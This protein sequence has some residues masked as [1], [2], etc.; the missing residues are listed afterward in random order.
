M[1]GQSGLPQAQLPCGCP[2][3]ASAQG[4]ASGSSFARLAGTLPLSIAPSSSGSRSSRL[5]MALR[6]FASS[7]R[8]G[9]LTLQEEGASVALRPWATAGQATSMTPAA[10][11]TAACAFP[12]I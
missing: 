5:R 3:A 12:S 8:T 9:S 10:A 2:S 7:S 11:V 4:G 6:P 1:R